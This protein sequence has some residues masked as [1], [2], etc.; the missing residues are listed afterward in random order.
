MS[1]SVFFRFG[2]TALALAA[3]AVAL[4]PRTAL[5]SGCRY[6]ADGRAARVHVQPYH[7][8]GTAGVLRAG[9]PAWGACGRVWNGAREWTRLER[10]VSGY[11]V[12]TRVR[13]S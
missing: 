9:R 8:A 7:D 6:R 2:L 11:V 3:L 10:P 13:R 4:V 1:P 5:A 12:S